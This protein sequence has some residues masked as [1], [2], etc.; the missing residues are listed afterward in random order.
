MLG[1]SLLKKPWIGF[2]SF[3]N[4]TVHGHDRLMKIIRLQLS[5]NSPKGNFSFQLEYGSVFE[6]FVVFKPS[7]D[8]L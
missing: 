7:M 4:T 1:D 3:V 6:G 5:Y 8:S 2:V